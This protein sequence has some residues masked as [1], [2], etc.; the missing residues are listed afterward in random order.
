MTAAVMYEQG[1]PAPYVDSRPF[2][3]EEV[4]LDGPGDGEILVEIRGAGLCHSDL[5]VI[6]GM[7]GPGR[8]PSWA[9]MKARGSSAK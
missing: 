9:A 4:E 8:C 1:L 7:R 2:H 5:S 3:I 6:E